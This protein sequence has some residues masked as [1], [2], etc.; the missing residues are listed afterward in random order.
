[1]ENTVEGRAGPHNSRP[2]V[3]GQG[4][5]VLPGGGCAGRGR[6]VCSLVPGAGAQSLSDAFWASARPG[7]AAW[8]LLSRCSGSEGEVSHQN[9][10]AFK[11]W[12]HTK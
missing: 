1:M 12:Q 3:R 6:G 4:T 5:S 11:F 10:L 9:F 7:L 2:G 8:P